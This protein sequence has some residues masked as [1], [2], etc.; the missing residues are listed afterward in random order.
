MTGTDPWKAPLEDG[1]PLYAHAMMAC[2]EG[3]AAR[4]RELL[5][6]LPSQDDIGDLLEFNGWPDETTLLKAASSQGHL[7]VVKLIVSCGA[8]P[9]DNGSDVTDDNDSTCKVPLHLAA[10][11]GHVDVVRWLVREGGADV[12]Q[13]DRNGCN[14]YHLGCVQGH[15][16]VVQFLVEEAGLDMD[17]PEA[18]GGTGLGWALKRGHADLAQ[19]LREQGAL[20]YTRGSSEDR[21]AKGIGA[22]YSY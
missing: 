16:D 3:D 7:D 9:N 15:T 6:G 17:E 13:C 11:C 5:M 21:G 14:A 12:R 1:R 18:F 8:D 4:L 20:P 19:W 22:I 10:A 2:M